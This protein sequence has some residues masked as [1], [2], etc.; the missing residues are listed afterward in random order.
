MFDC[1]FPGSIWF[2]FFCFFEG[3]IHLVC[4]MLLIVTWAYWSFSPNHQRFVYVHGPMRPWASGLV[5]RAFTT[6]PTSGRLRPC[7]AIRLCVVL[8]A[9]SKQADI[10][11]TARPSSSGFPFNTYKEKLNHASGPDRL[12]RGHDSGPVDRR[13]T[14]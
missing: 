7:D 6:T 14:S 11:P 3:G 10:L 5:D 2:V 1:L 4:W 9:S 13:P 8:Q 12:S